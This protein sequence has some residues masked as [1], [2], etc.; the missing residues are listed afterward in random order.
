MANVL[1][2][3]LVFSPDNV[4]TAQIMAGIAEDL[5]K[6]GHSVRVLTSTP[7]FHRDPSMEARQPIRKWW[8][9]FVRRS[10]LNGVPAY[11]VWM[12]N[13]GIWP[14]LRMLSWIWFHFACTVVSLFLE[15]PQMVI[16]CS[17]PLTIGVNAWLI[18]VL[19]RCR[20][21]YNV[22]ELY[23]DIA[24]NLGVIR[25]RRAVRFFQRMERFI[26]RHAFAVTSITEGMCAKIRERTDPEKVHLIPNFVD[27]DEMKD[28]SLEENTE[29]QFAA[30]FDLK[31]RFVIT[32]AGNMGIPQKL[33]VLLEA[34]SMLTSDVV[35]LFVGAGGVKESLMKRAEELKLENVR[36]VEYQPISRMPEIYAASSLFYVGQDP[37]ASSDGIP[38]KIYR[39]LG[40]RKPIL[41]VTTKGSDLSRFVKESEAGIVVDDFSPDTVAAEIVK[42]SKE[43]DRQRLFSECGYRYV[44]QMFSRKKISSQY[45]SLVRNITR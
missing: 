37:H 32:Y 9:P 38:S 41:A 14:P 8:G 22:Q 31:D 30:E 26:Y 16:A 3:S 43:K 13:K 40:N 2:L 33:D 12:P 24:V 5:R 11:H 1:L 29:N 7:H 42:L 44:S 45:E 39:I 28:A 10:E 19:R 20:Y 21:I 17:P 4:S 27:L 18:S 35:I 25:N 23:P 15:K 36:F 34:A 6:A